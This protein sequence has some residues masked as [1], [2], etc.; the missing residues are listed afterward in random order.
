[1]S[2]NR[3]IYLIQ[4]DPVFRRQ[5]NKLTADEKRRVLELID[6]DES[7]IALALED[8]SAT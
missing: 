6:G 2:D 5:W 8:L 7:F 4:Q 1:M 3:I